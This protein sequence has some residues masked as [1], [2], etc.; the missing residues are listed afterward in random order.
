[1][2]KKTEKKLQ[3]G[4]IKIAS[5]S[6]AKQNQHGIATTFCSFIICQDDMSQGAAVCSED[7]CRF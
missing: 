2:K 3:L 4:K 5:L 7:S 6:P 1:M